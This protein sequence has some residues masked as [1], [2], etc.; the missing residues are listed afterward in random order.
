VCLIVRTHKSQSQHNLLIVGCAVAFL[1]THFT[2]QRSRISVRN[3]HVLDVA[4]AGS[5]DGTPL[6]FHHGAPSSL[7]LFEPFIEA[8]MARRLRYVSY[9]RPGYGNSTRQPGRTVSD[10][11]TDTANILDQLGADRFYVIGWS[12]GGPH[13]LACAALLPQRVI[14]ASSIA[15]IAPWG[16]QNLDWLAG[17][18]KENVEE[19]QAALTGP[20]ELRSFLERVGPGFAQVSGDQIIAAF[21]DLVDDVDKMVLTGQLGVFLA[22]NIR[23]ALRNG[24]W[25]WFDDDIAFIRDWGFDLARIDVPVTVWHGAKDRMAPYAHGRWLAEHL[26]GA[27]ARLLA[28][29]GHL[30]LAVGSFGRILDDLIASEKR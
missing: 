25:G 8:A 18:G 14:A 16:S 28:E 6:V 20:D 23:E 1:A 30:S 29:H 7:I 3:E 22:D 12:G 21:G 19:F 2:V 13:A 26:P 17:M 27:R 15:G 11:S 4:V 5:E 10:C 24:F 9:S